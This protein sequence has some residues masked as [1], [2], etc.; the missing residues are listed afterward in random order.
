MLNERIRRALKFK[1]YSQ[2]HISIPNKD[3]HHFSIPIIFVHNFQIK[4]VNGI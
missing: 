3:S 2:D 4:F 1:R